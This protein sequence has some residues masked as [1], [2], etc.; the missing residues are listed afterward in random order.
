[1]IPDHEVKERS[2]FF[3]VPTSTIERDYTQNWLLTSLYPIQ[4]ALKGGTGVRKVYIEN[5]RFSDDLDFTLLQTYDS[6]VLKVFIRDAIVS[7]H[8]ESGIVFDGEIRLNQSRTGFRVTV[9]F[10]SSL[11]RSNIRIRINLDL[12]DPSNEE[13]L[14]P[15]QER[16]IIHPYSDDLKAVAKV[17]S[18]EEMMAEKIRSLFQRSRPRDLY[19]VYHLAPLVGIADVHPIFQKKCAK[20]DIIPILSQVED[21]KE[22]FSASW[23][24]ALVHQI[25]LLPEFNAVFEGVLA[26]L[27]QYMIK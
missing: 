20:K 25:K 12:T 8:D 11:T 6:E 13:I 2:R 15:I 3:G 26:L 9:Y 24:T 14:L 16:K 7:V 19:D 21:R 17:Y 18:L 4:M 23:R 22:V 1:M 10:I 27:K 5:Y